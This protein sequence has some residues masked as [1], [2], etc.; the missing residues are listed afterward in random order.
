MTTGLG[1]G[2]PTA[3]AT[4]LLGG[5]VACSSTLRALRLLG[6]P[7]KSRDRS[8]ADVL[9]LIQVLTGQAGRFVLERTPDRHWE[10]RRW[11]CP[12]NTLPRPWRRVAAHSLCV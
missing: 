2:S 8:L 5:R 1:T 4:A 3:L 12:T 11:R 10:R 9:V 7:L 6:S